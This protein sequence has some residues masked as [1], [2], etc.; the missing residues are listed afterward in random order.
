[1]ANH[2]Q[3]IYLAVGNKYRRRKIQQS[4]R[5]PTT[6]RNPRD[7]QLHL[8]RGAPIYTKAP[9]TEIT[10]WPDVVDVAP[11]PS[12]AMPEYQ[13]M[14][15]EDNNAWPVSRIADAPTEDEQLQQIADVYQE[16]YQAAEAQAAKDGVGTITD[17]MLVTTA[18]ISVGLMVIIG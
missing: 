4:H 13:R 14:I 15:C 5:E 11:P 17:R 7:Q 10:T 16:Y 9:P 6:L 1:M 18:I 3:V 8:L 2:I 12:I